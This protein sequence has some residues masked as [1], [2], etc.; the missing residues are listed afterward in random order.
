MLDKTKQLISN[1]FTMQMVMLMASI[2]TLLYFILKTHLFYN[3]ASPIGDEICFIDA[4]TL[5]EKN[6]LYQ[7]LCHGK[8]SPVFSILSTFLNY[9][10]NDILI[11]YRI[12]SVIATLTTLFLVFN[13]A[14]NKLKIAGHYLAGIIILT[15]SFLGFRIYWQGLNDAIFHLLVVI[16]FYMLYN[17]QFSKNTTRNFIYLGI[18]FGLMIGT[19][20]LAF[21][22]LPC[23][24][25]FFL[26]STKNTLIVGTTTLLVGLIF[27]LPSLTNGNGFSDQDKEPKNGMTWA[28]KNYLSQ[29]LIYEN[30][31]KVGNRVTW[32]ELENYIKENGKETL[33]TKFTETLTLSPEITLNS[34]YNNVIFSVKNIY[35]QFLGFGLLLLFYI[36][37]F[38]LKN[39]EI[40][41]VNLKF[42]LKFTSSFWLHTLLISLVSFT[43]IE[44]RWYTSFIYLAIVMTYWFFQN[45]TN[46]N[47]G[48]K[49]FLLKLNLFIIIMYQLQF[50]VTDHNLL[51]AYLRQ[52]V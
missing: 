23:F 6:G 52:L 10:I 21:V 16:S 3:L 1:L 9:F 41:D 20:F 11:T 15:I 19:R 34:F 44:P 27:H 17:I 45:L 47:E 2:S 30:K 13:F 5:I 43:Q 14:K 36:Y 7:E 46:I 32:G 31:L 18:I 49:A 40:L 26:K 50:I 12:I 24:V 8:I 51:S 39:K 42:N 29:K 28:Q 22:I 48:R 35:F 37:Y 4:N 25:F 38:A 33:P